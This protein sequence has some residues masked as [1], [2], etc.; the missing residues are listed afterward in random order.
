MATCLATCNVNGEIIHVY[1]KQICM[2]AYEYDIISWERAK[3]VANN[4]VW[5]YVQSYAKK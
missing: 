1:Y 2:S 5:K 3:S 4:E